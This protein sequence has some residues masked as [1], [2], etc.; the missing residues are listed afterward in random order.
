MTVSIFPIGQ[1]SPVSAGF[2][3]GLPPSVETAARAAHARAYASGRTRGVGEAHWRI[4]A[5]HFIASVALLA[6]ERSDRDAGDADD[7]QIA[8][9]I[10]GIAS[11]AYGLDDLIKEGQALSYS[12]T[13]IDGLQHVLLLPFGERSAV[14]ATAIFALKHSSRDGGQ[15]PAVA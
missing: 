6:A 5:E 9:L 11:G 7:G 2:F 8:V 15:A 10:E 1:A 12:K 13:L 14:I 3:T 4:T